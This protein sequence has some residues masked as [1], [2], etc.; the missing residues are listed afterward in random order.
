MDNSIADIPIHQVIGGYD[1]DDMKDSTQEAVNSSADHMLSS[2]WVK[3]ARLN[4]PNSQDSVQATLSTGSLSG[5][6][7]SLNVKATKPQSHSPM[8]KT[9]SNTLS[10][11][12][13][14][15]LDDNLE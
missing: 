12:G 15:M 5:V 14:V 13:H 7:N 4:S 8:D 11:S 1:S 6:P 3:R 10:D 9:L 2:F